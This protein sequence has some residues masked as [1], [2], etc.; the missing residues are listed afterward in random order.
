MRSIVLILS[1]L[2]ATSLFSQTSE[3]KEIPFEDTIV[4]PINYQPSKKYLLSICLH[5]LFGSGKSMAKD[6]SPY[7]QYMNMIL[8]CPNGNIPD[9][10]RNAT[11]WGNE[12]SVEYLQR[13]LT[14]IKNKYKIEGDPFLIG[15]SQGAN[16]A[17]YTALRDPSIWKTVAILSGG[18]SDIPKENYPNVSLI[19]MLFISGDTGSGEIYTLKRMNERLELLSPYSKIQ[20]IIL[21]GHTHETSTKF[22][23]S[24]LKWYASQSKYF[25]KS[26]WIFKG[27]FMKDY[28]QGEDEILNL[29]YESA[30]TSFKNSL[31]LNPVYPPSVF[32]FA[33]TSL[34]TG[35]TKDFKNNFFTFLELYSR[36]PDLPREPLVRIFE[37]IRITFR[38]DR[39][40]RE[41]F[42]SYFE[43]S[44][45]ENE[46]N[47]DIIFVAELNFLLSH[48]HR[49]SAQFDESN[50]RVDNA[51]L[52]YQSMSKR[53]QDFKDFEVQ[54]KIE[55]IEN[56]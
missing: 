44:L 18:Y 23:Y 14:Y 36:N 42:I 6:F 35:K 32:R 52:L 17:I 16:Q 29:N 4:L 33:H 22:A 55:I 31:K 10:S 5:G 11:K 51:R 49:Y 39:A 27:D 48:L 28:L 12:D 41:H 50:Q 3:G 20:Q 53:S 2:L 47:L 34:L 46:S 25:K 1:F 26:F 24:I 38:N 40:L 43:A 7:T 56:L 37:D 30:Y 15:F 19:K 9:P 13:Y 21:N 8:A 54:K 45:N